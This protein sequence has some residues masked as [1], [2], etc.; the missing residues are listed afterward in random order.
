M[1]QITD[2]RQLSPGDWIYVAQ[3]Q[4]PFTVQTTSERYA[5]CTRPAF[6]SVLYFI[7]DFIEQIMGTEN[8]I[9]PAGAETPEQREEMMQ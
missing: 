3:Y 6:G 2:G 7:A 8:L 4:R 5:I 9:F 1:I